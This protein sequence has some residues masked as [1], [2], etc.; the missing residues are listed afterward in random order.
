M[1]N[2][3][4]LG[5]ARQMKCLCAREVIF[6]TATALLALHC[7]EKAPTLEL[8]DE[9]QP[10]A[11]P[12]KL[13]ASANFPASET[14]FGLP[15]MAGMRVTQHFAK[16]AYVVGRVPF[17]SA[18]EHVRDNVLAS[19]A[20]VRLGRIIFPK[21]YIKDD[22]DKRLYRI[23]VSDESQG[24]ARISIS[25]ITAPPSPSGLTAAER[26]K[27]AGRNPDGTLIDPNSVF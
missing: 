4:A 2:S 16:V 1:M 15:I 11:S 27:R 14:A 19:V 3:A 6:L 17:D 12:E 13:T 21:V 24:R 26:W 25:D 23:E 7:R 22:R 9:P 18:V 10:E 5:F 8:V 20:E